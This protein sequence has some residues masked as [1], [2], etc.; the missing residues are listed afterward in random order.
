MRLGSCNIIFSK[1]F[2]VCEEK[3]HISNRKS[4]GKSR[5][6]LIVF[7][8]IEALC[9]LKE[10]KKNDPTKKKKNGLKIF[11]RHFTEEEH[12][13]SYSLVIRGI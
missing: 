4:T 7:L 8:K 3:G 11:S 6:W 12:R 10:R 9:K 2:N 5:T 1:C 13:N